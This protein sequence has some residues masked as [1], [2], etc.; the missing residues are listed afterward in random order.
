M[1]SGEHERDGEGEGDERDEGV[2]GEKKN[3]GGEETFA[4]I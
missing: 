2:E 1:S 3:W 4:I